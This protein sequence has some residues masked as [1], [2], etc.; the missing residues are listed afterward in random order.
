MCAHR[1][2]DGEAAVAQ[3]HEENLRQGAQPRR[4]ASGAPQWERRWDANAAPRPRLQVAHVLRRA[5]LR[6]LRLRRR[7]HVAGSLRRGVAVRAAG[8]L[9]SA[10]VHKDGA[11]RRRLIRRRALSRAVRD[12]FPCWRN[13]A[14]HR[15]DR[16][17][18]AHTWCARARSRHLAQ[19][20][21]DGADAP[22]AAAFVS[23][24][25]CGLS[26]ANIVRRGG[27]TVHIGV[28][29]SSAAVCH[30]FA[31]SAHPP[32]RRAACRQTA[33]RRACGTRRRAAR[34]APRARLQAQPLAAAAPP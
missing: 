7:L 18:S 13:S 22:G 30:F 21:R 12:T 2:A 31:M 5:K 3:K 32:R 15:G 1:A 33:A 19:R 27:V 11:A 25:G 28:G 26:H 4:A 23:K 24:R 29:A 14:R 10:S 16:E 20:T 6:L 9:R 8:C 17:G 34:R